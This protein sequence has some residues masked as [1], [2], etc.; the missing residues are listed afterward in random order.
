MRKISV[1]AVLICLVLTPVLSAN[2]IVESEKGKLNVLF[3]TGGHSYDEESFYKMLDKLSGVSY[4]V[5]AHPAAYGMLKADKINKYDVVCLYDMPQKITEEAQKDFIAMLEQGKGLVVLHHALGSYDDFWPEYTKIAGGQYHSS[6]W[7]KDGIEQPLSTYKHDVVFDV[8]VVD[9]DHPV[10]RGIENFTIT[11]ETYG[12]IEILPT[13]YP[14]LSTNE[15]TSSPL[16]CW[17]NKYANSRIVTL[18]LGH[19]KLAWE[20]SSFLRILSQAIRWVGQK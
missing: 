1:I 19:D 14:L 11:D 2:K 16:L 18:T 7:K 4:N 9:S 17:T 3:V 20:N 8:K 15:P 13:V 10:T 12:F 5:V 6:P